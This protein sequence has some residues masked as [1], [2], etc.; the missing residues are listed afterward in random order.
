MTLLLARSQKKECSVD[1]AGDFLLRRYSLKCSS[2]MHLHWQSISVHLCTDCTRSV[3]STHTCDSISCSCV[4]VS[5]RF[6]LLLLAQALTE[7]LLQSLAPDLMLCCAV[8]CEHSGHS[9]DPPC[10]LCL[11]ASASS[12]LWAQWEWGCH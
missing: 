2:A 11:S 1:V 7:C 12:Q 5:L 8:P 6:C 10:K 4:M 3:S 9:A